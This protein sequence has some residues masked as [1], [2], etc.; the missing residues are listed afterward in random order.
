MDMVTAAEMR[1]IDR[2]AMEEFGI[3]GVVLMENAG[4]S[5][6][7]AV[8]RA[9]GRR[10]LI[11]C[12][13]G[14]NGGDGLVA[15]RHLYREK[16]VGV[17]LAAPPESYR[18]DA[19]INLNILGKLGH[20]L[21]VLS[22]RDDLRRLASDLAR[23]DLVVDA[24]L[25][26]G[27]ARAVTGMLSEAIGLVNDCGVP[28]LAVDIPSG[29]CADSGRILGIAV[30]AAKTVTFGLP[31]RG[32]FL[33]PG[34]ACAGETEVADIGLPP[35]LLSGHG[36]RLLTAEEVRVKL[37]KRPPDAHKG[38]FGTVLLVAGSAG[39][40]GAAVLAARG[41]LRGGAGLVTVAAPFSAQRAVAG[42]VP[43]ATTLPL[44]ENSRGSLGVEALPLLRE[45]WR[46]SSV[47][48]VG[49]GLTASAEVAEVLSGLLKECQLPVVLDADALNVLAAYPHIMSARGAPAVITPHPGEAGRLL[50]IP[51]SE[52]Q[53]DRVA[54][55][56]RLAERFNC[57][58]V[59][60]GAYTLIAAPGGGVAL[61]PTGNS[62][63]ATGG[64]GDVLT[65]LLAALLAAG[66]AVTAAA[67]AA[68]WLHGLAGDEAAAVLG[69][70]ALTAG[71]LAD[72]LPRA[73]QKT[74]TTHI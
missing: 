71:D 29:V 25:G 53:S 43:E 61:N 12:G 24:L 33:F 35:A 27:T 19:L 74:R 58:A 55:A 26:T 68:A 36:L 22:G 30:R 49:P 20:P 34:A 21:Q 42:L 1:E 45:R 70:D 48:A 14:N 8:R 64:S 60:K 28:V 9:G 16:E 69:Q 56:R 13:P 54:A 10:V 17:W 15:A 39:M 57:T 18:G 72:Y 5:V 11:L 2:R 73:W 32:L 62:G 4:L 41:A 50:G 3:P 23:A 59:L 38:T 51:A 47:L 44:P 65:G 31:K 40:A 63:M 52:I 67:E 7:R 46:H 66:M 37:P 6:V